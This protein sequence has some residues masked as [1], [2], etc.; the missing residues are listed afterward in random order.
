MKQPLTIDELTNLIKMDEAHLSSIKQIPNCD[1]I[2]GTEHLIRA[3]EIRI[4]CM[5]SHRDKTEWR[6]SDD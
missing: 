3:I 6:Y 2:R 1:E 5:K 4:H